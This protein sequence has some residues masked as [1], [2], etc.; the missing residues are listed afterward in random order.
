M[1]PKEWG[2]VGF[3]APPLQPPL[4]SLILTHWARCIGVALITLSELYQPGVLASLAVDEKDL[5]EFSR[6]L[7]VREIG[8]FALFGFFR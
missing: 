2:D 7:R 3:K 4:Q 1:I 8:Y 5:F 6:H